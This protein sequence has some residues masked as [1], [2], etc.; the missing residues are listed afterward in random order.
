VFTTVQSQ[1]RGMELSKMLWL[2]SAS[3]EVWLERRTNYA[4]SLAVMSM[5]GYI[6]GR[7]AELVSV[8]RGKVVQSES[9]STP[10]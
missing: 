1:T 8:R 5:A 6:L 9:S 4:R 10:C 2:K 7:L 3:S